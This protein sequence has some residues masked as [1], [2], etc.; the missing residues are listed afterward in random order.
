MFRRILAAVL[1]FG[2]VS[3]S[4]FDLLE[5]LIAAP[6]A[7]AYTQD[8]ATSHSPRWN[9]HPSLTNNIIE[10]AISADAVFTPLIQGNGSSTI[11]PAQWS[12]LRA[13]DLHKLYRVLLI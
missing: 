5:D 4:A 3:L 7:S 13:L 6:D 8:G 9:R 12:F 10:S 11:I 1:I 2:W